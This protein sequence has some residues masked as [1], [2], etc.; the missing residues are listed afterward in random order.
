M[1]R[2]V[3]EPPRW[4]VYP[5]LAALVAQMGMIGAGAL[6]DDYTWA[7]DL[8]SSTLANVT[9]AGFQNNPA[10]T[11]LWA[12]LY[13]AAIVYVW[14][15]R[16]WL[17]LGAEA[18]FLAAIV[19][20]MSSGLLSSDYPGKVAVNIAHLAGGV[21]LGTAAAISF[22]SS[23]K[24]GLSTAARALG[25][26]VGLHLCFVALVPGLGVDSS[27]W[28]MGFTGNRNSLGA[29]AALA[30]VANLASLFERAQTRRRAH[31]VW[32]VVG[33]AALAGAGSLTSILAALGGSAV[34]AWL[35]TSRSVGSS[36][37]RVATAT[38][39]A[40]GVVA[41]AYLILMAGEW[42]VLT[43]RMGR[44]SDVSGR[45]PLWELAIEL[46]G[47]RPIFGWGFDDNATVI[48]RT[49]LPHTTFHN[50]YLDVA[51]RGGTVGLVLLLAALAVTTLRVVQTKNPE[52][53][54]FRD[55][56]LACIA[57][58]GIHNL[59]EV[60]L[61][62]GRNA[63]WLYLLF[64]VAIAHTRVPDDRYSMVRGREADLRRPA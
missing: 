56:F 11:V 62:A 49:Y 60:S 27:G 28:W 12:A 23:L 63:L 29:L 4:G 10:I 31:V 13:V 48:S 24:E 20:L 51:V 3:G 47:E 64:L 36:Q 15:N 54:G 35:W 14:R 41:A 38:A 42:S 45:T 18:A 32:V 9:T 1:S 19:V 7:E 33:V 50:G 43:D 37:R 8:H 53:R 61:L 58:L 30:T 57:L 52:R 39:L 22:A 17:A 40:G 34:I 21:A 25:I 26:A 2:T 55:A 46:I 16:G 5:F 6:V 44:T 59:A